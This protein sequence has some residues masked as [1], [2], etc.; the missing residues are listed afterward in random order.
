MAQTTVEGEYYF[1]KMEIASGFNFSKEGKF[2]FFYSYGAIDRTATGS[3]IVKGDS[4]LLKSDKE[5][6]KDFTI[7]S[8]S[9]NG[10]GSIVKFDYTNKYLLKNIVCIFVVDGNQQQAYSDENGQVNMQLDHCDT[11]YAFH[12][13]FPDVPTLIKDKSNSNNNF[14]LTLNP[15]L[16]QVSFKD[17]HFK[18]KDSKTIECSNNYFMD[19]S[20]IK[21]LKE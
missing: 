2:Q 18:I 12:S 10:N 5:P 9:K 19:A 17:I 16:E 11:I 8:Q 20:D 13:L 7:T 3:F 1:R 15:S 6:G 4:L 21:F 14:V